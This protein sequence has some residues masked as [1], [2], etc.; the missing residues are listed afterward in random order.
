K[1]LRAF[2]T[3]W[4]PQ[5]T[6]IQESKSNDFSTLPLDDL[7]GNLKVYEV[8]LEKDS[9]ISKSKKEKYKSLTLKARKVLSEEEASSSDSEDEECHGE[10]TQ[11]QRKEKDDRMCF[12]CVNPNHFIS[13]CPK[14]FYNDQK[15]FVLGCWSDSEDDSKMEEI[16]LMALDIM[17]SSSSLQEMLEMQK[18]PKDKHGIGYTEDIASTSIVKTKKLIPKDDKMP[19]VEPASLVPSAREPSTEGIFLGYSPN[20]KA[21]VILNK[22]TMRVKESLNV[23]FDESLPHKSSPL[24]DDDILENE[25]IENQE[26]DLEIKENEP[27]IKEIVNIKETKDHHIDSVI[28]NGYSLKDKNEAKTAKTEHENEKS[29]KS[30]SQSQKVPIPSWQSYDFSLAMGHG[31]ISMAVIARLGDQDYLMAEIED[32]DPLTQQTQDQEAPLHLFYINRARNQA[33]EESSVI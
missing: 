29:V 26:K 1:F 9:K 32:L 7:I 22:E 14:H 10:L 24:V 8:V 25:I 5:V 4:R 17:S 28:G 27:L 20:S 2:P 11:N 23:R 30:Q 12:K 13:D 21:C 33:W 31:T 3:K 18:P 15:A 16:C 19:T 6:T